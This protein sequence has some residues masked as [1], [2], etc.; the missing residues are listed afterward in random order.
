MS[1]FNL[2]YPTV[3]NQQESKVIKSG[4]LLFL[5]GA[6]G[7]GKSTLVHKFST[8]NPH[9]V[10]YITAHRQ[11][12]FHSNAM[13]LTPA[14]REQ[15]EQQMYARDQQA[16]ARYR[17]DYAAQRSQVTIFDLIDS[18]NVD[19][20]KIADTLRSGDIN[21]A[22]SLSEVQAPIS[23]MND[24]LQLSNL[25]IKIQVD[26]GSKLF[27]V[28]GDL[29]PYSIAELS[30]GERNALLIIANVLTAPSNTLILLDEP[31]RHLHRAIVSPLI[32]T[33]LNYR[34][35]CA[36]VVSTHDVSL[37]LDQKNTSALLVRNY[38][39]QPQYWEIDYIEAVED[40][41]EDLA[42]AIFANLSD[43]FS[44]TFN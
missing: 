44:Y 1:E 37:L 24:I 34:N 23:K 29:P 5:V 18:E 7:T 15:N 8:L 43:S 22:K 31:E 19:A 33:L 2:T 13:D 16:T 27:A 41:D 40:L 38:N 35:D 32:T 30:D 4:E 17:D 9:K 20:R 26:K 21:E 12:W 10:R 42:E 39:H 25:N 28:K 36:F 6:N 11:I 3:G 14:A